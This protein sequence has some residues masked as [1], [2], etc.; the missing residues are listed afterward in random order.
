LLR[1]GVAVQVFDRSIAALSGCGSGID[2]ARF[3]D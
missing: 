2:L 1:P 3:I